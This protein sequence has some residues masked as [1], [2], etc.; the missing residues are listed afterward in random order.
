M[1]DMAER[2]AKILETIVTS[3]AIVRLVISDVSPNDEQAIESIGIQITVQ[4]P[5]AQSRLLGLVQREA[6]DR[7]LGV[8]SRLRGEAQQ[9]VDRSTRENF[10]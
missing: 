4:L 9:A 2:D 5:G 7:A 6:I 1:T 3:D 8:L 10:S